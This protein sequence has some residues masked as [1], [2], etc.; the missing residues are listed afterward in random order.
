MW[1]PNLIPECPCV[2]PQLSV[3]CGNAGTCPLTAL[4]NR[5][6]HIK[7][8]IQHFFCLLSIESES[9]SFS[10]LCKI[11]GITHSC[12][13]Q[14]NSVEV[15]K[16]FEYLEEIDVKKKN[17]TEKKTIRSSKSVSTPTACIYM[18]HQHTSIF[19]LLFFYVRLLFS[20]KLNIMKTG[21]RK[22]KKRMYAFVLRVTMEKYVVGFFSVFFFFFLFL[23]Q[24][25]HMYLKHLAYCSSAVLICS[26]GLIRVKRDGLG[27][28]TQSLCSNACFE[29]NKTAIRRMAPTFSC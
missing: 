29:P 1:C 15:N 8:Q 11:I 23:S 9:F 17:Q 7:Y 3:M 20:S 18:G 12:Q 5:V 2:L 28:Q 14:C 10:S 19:I 25:L 13:S 27:P 22:K 4:H 26:L 16:M 24:S 21:V 6:I